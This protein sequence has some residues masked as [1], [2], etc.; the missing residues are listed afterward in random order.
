MKA[1]EGSVGRAL[2][3]SSGLVFLLAVGLAACGDDPTS[4]GSNNLRIRLTDNH[5]EDLE[6]VNIFFTD[7]TVKPAGKP[8][9]TVPLTLADNPQDLLVLRD[10]VVDLAAGNV[11][12]GTYEFIMI[13]LDEDRSNVVEAGETKSLRIPSEEVKI[14]G[15]FTV[16]EDGTTSVTLD[17]DAERSLVKEG[18]GEFGTGGW[19]L[20][21]VIAISRVE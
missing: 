5:I 4:P 18:F 19:V 21:P 15:R 9:E 2:A 20:R 10:K 8:V 6:Q 13:N 16:L 11:S 14:L 1:M 17:F 3:L 7:L 12:P